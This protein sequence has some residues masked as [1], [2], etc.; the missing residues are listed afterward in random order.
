MLT[1]A[2]VKS[3]TPAV[4]ERSSTALS[5]VLG[6]NHCNNLKGF[7]V[8]MTAW[9]PLVLVLTPYHVLIHT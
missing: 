7:T 6:Q 3:R 2:F 5:T 1:H 9:Q 4:S 8:L